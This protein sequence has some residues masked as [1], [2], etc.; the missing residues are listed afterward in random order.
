MTTGLIIISVLFAGF[1]VS[2]GWGIRGFVIGGEKGALLPGALLGIGVA[3]FAAGDKGHELWTFFA[4][5]GAL[6]MFYGGTETYAQ[7]MSFLLSRDVKGPYYG[8]LKKGVIGIFLKGGLWF[9]IPGFVLAMLPAALSGIYSLWEIILMFAL[10]PFVSFIGTKIFNTPYD[11]EKKKFP[12]LYFSLDRREEWG[13]NVMIIAVLTVFAAI[14][15]DFFALG[16]GLTGFISGGFGFLIGLVFYDIERRQG[17]KIFGKLCRMGYIDGW[18]IMEH[19]FG[20]FAGG[21]L[22]LYFALNNKHLISLLDEA[23]LNVLPLGQ[24]SFVLALVPFILLLISAI[25]YPICKTVEKKTGK[26]PDIHIFELIER[27]LWS[28]V[29]LIFI[30]LGAP[31]AAAFGTFG[32]LA[33]AL[34]EKCTIEWYEKSAY[35]KYIR[36]AF[37]VLWVVLPVWFCFNYRTLSLPDTM[38]LYTAGYTGACIIYSFLPDRIKDYRSKKKTFAGAFGSGITVTGHLAVQSVILIIMSYILVD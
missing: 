19:T 35:K 31:T 15:G 13:S 10:F 5:A 29:P 9:C 8:Q 30:F 12:K 14:K 34:C 28:A 32:T 24:D 1:A 23:D 6:S 11:R 37:G 18:K 25:Q 20:A 38:L 33:W 36:A 2:Y 21:A 22:M 16:A 26:E 7:T 3:F 17:K 27:P 4:A